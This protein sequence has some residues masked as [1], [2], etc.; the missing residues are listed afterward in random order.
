M[1]L[2]GDGEKLRQS[3]NNLKEV[4]LRGGP[5]PEHNNVRWL[6]VL[7]LGTQ[8][9]ACRKDFLGEVKWPL[10]S[11]RVHAA[12]TSDVHILNAHNQYGT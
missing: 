9:R 7:R 1:T 2:P 6:R 11:S 4:N 3:N 12:L 8:Y 10:P 5:D